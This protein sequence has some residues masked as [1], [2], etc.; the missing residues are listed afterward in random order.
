MLMPF[1]YRHTEVTMTTSCVYRH[2]RVSPLFLAFISVDIHTIIQSRV[3]YKECQ[4]IN[5]NILIFVHKV[6]NAVYYDVNNCFCQKSL[7]LG[8]RQGIIWCHRKATSSSQ[9]AVSAVLLHGHFPP[10]SLRIRRNINRGIVHSKGSFELVRFDVQL[11]SSRRLRLSW[12]FISFP[13]ASVDP[14]LP[15]GR[16]NA[17]YHR[18]RV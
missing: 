1:P 5:S 13:C 10:T 7:P 15:P 11:P 14:L 6:G 2:R 9:P 4:S 8:A 12:T 16:R 18:N 3:T 17:V